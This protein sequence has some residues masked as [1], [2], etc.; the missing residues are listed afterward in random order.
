MKITV[1]GTGYVGLVTGTCFA[2]MGNQVY[3]VDIIEEKIQNLKNN[4]VDIYE[5]QLNELVKSNQ[6]K[7]DLIF[8]TD[9]KFAI[10]NS[11]LYFIAVGTPMA[12]DGSCN[13]EYVFNVAQNIGEY[14]NH[15]CY[16]ITKST[17]PVGTSHKI[18]KI[19]QKKLHERNKS[20]NFNLISN[21]EFLKE[22]TAVS[23]CLRP[24]RIVIG[25]ENE[26]SFEIMKQLYEHFIRNSYNYVFMNINSAEMTKY[27]ANAMLATKISFMNELAGIC[28]K[29]GVDINEVR[30]GIGTDQRIGF[31]FIYAG[32]GYG[33]SCFPKDV[34]A[35]IN[36]GKINNSP[37]EILE[38]VNSTNN[39]AKMYIPNKIFNHFGEDLTE[40]TFGVWGLSFKPDTDDMR[41]A[42]SITIINSLLEKGA[43]IK[44]Y[45]PKA[46]KNAKNI[47]KDE[48]EY[49][50]N[51]FEVVDESDAL[52]LITEWKEFRNPNFEIIK[53]KL[54]NPII[55]DGRNQFDK[56]YLNK[57]GFKYYQIGVDDC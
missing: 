57:M 15:D 27:A 39:N 20:F 21:P 51:R 22:G 2:E 14:M 24:D 7:G 10:E 19:I 42:S 11:D 48:I 55:F 25:A 34:N 37:T 1:I 54:K 8:T 52:I 41:E 3:C 44:V 49:C 12:E 35:L 4:I 46:M 13:L 31:S 23:D 33:G 43:K 17:V 50:N 26:E 16:V 45:D 40:L 56:R 29:T 32:C 38:A 5:P 53:N 30:K 36:I 18:G 9:I 47:F 6:E 28:D